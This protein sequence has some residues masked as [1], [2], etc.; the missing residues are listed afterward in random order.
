ML[1][2][3]YKGSDDEMMV[4]RAVLHRFSYETSY[5]HNI[6]MADQRLSLEYVDNSRGKSWVA[7]SKS[8]LASLTINRLRYGHGDCEIIV[9]SFTMEP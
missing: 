5:K 1:E 8:K 3:K 4:V 9:P 7:P 2:I 6:P